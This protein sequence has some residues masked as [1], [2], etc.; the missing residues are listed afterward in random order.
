M[1]TMKHTQGEDSLELIGILL[2]ILMCIVMYIL[3]DILMGV[4]LHIMTITCILHYIIT[5]YIMYICI[6][7]GIEVYLIIN[8]IKMMVSLVIEFEEREMVMLYKTAHTPNE[9]ISKTII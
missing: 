5:I 2:N 3:I 4:L 8:V 1:A 7:I 9:R 6:C